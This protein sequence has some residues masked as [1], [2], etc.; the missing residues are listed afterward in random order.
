MHEHYIAK[1]AFRREKKLHWSSGMI[2]L[3]GSGGPGF[4]SRMRPSIFLSIFHTKCLAGDI[5]D[6]WN[7]FILDEKRR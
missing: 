5:I 3:S 7:V 1:K 4:E 6:V 2:P